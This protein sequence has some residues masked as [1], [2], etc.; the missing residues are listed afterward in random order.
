MSPAD[1]L[2][3][4]T[5]RLAGRRIFGGCGSCNAFKTLEEDPDFPAIFHVRI[6]HDAWC[7]FLARIEWN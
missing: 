1:R 2:R 5:R 7:P 3:D 6:H 4:L